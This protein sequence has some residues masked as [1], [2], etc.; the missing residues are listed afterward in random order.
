MSD[1][2]RDQ[3][4]C[5]A[6]DALERIARDGSLR[7]APA[8][9]GFDGFVDSII[10]VVD[11]RHSMRMD[12]FDPISTIPDFAARVGAAAGKSANIELVVEEDRFGGNGP[13]YAGALG[14]LGMPTTYIG[15]VARDDASPELMPL[16][17]PFA[18]RCEEVIP[19]A[20]PAHTDA[21]E[22]EDGKIM[23]GKP[24]N[25]QSVTWDRLLERVGLDRLRSQC[26]RSKLV[27]IVNWTL[28]GGVQ[29][30]WEGLIRD[31]FPGLPRG[32]GRRVFIDLS[33]PAKRTDEDVRGAMT[34]L[35]RM[36]DLVP[37]TLGLN[38][39]E[40]E[41]VAGVLGIRAHGDAAS[42][43]ES[44]RTAAERIRE[45]SGL[46]CIV[47]HPRE[48]AAAAESSGASAWFEGP[49]T[50]RPRLS[51]GA[52]DH[53]G[54]GFSFGQVHGLPVEQSLAVGCAVSGAYVRDAESPRLARLISF[55]RELPRADA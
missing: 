33:D 20:A 5:A 41:R 51:T 40:S 22:F 42:A 49:F 4:A 30:I 8:L 45:R 11:R 34:T 53:F 54:A 55:L 38:L 28:C 32:A 37:V 48:G 2:E 1:H 31:V 25:V 3:I 26:E 19:V 13:L 44:L 50:A 15:A 6:A 21:L 36:N 24:A 18:A 47:I 16:Y 12:D 39:A 27:G 9:A 46:E 23:L 52:G 43:G 10:R 7:G 35:G 17:E 29:A 14:Q